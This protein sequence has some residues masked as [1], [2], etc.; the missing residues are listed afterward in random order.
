MPSLRTRA[1]GEPG[2]AIPTKRS[3]KVRHCVDRRLHA[4]RRRV[5]CFIDVPENSR[6]VATHDDH[7][8]G[9]FLGFALPA[10][11]RAWIAQIG[12]A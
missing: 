5:G 1:T 6:R 7:A 2:R 4:L 8:A 3:R 12:L 9:R 11:I 10:R